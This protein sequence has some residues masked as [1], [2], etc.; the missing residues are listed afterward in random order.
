M[1]L[2]VENEAGNLQSVHGVRSFLAKQLQIEPEIWHAVGNDQWQLV[3]DPIVRKTLACTGEPTLKCLNEFNYQYTLPLGQHAG[4][5]L[6]ANG[7]IN[8]EDPELWL[9]LANA[10]CNELKLRSDNQL[11]KLENEQF[12]RQAI[13]SYEELNFLKSATHEMGNA[14]LTAGVPPF[15]ETILNSLRNSIN[16]QTIG[17]IVNQKHELISSMGISGAI[18]AC[19][20]RSVWPD[21]DRIVDKFSDSVSN[22]PFIKNHCECD[23]ECDE[24]DFLNNF[25]ITSLLHEEVVIGWLVAVNRNGLE[26]GPSQLGSSV[27]ASEREFGTIEATILEA[28]ST[29]IKTHITNVNSVREQEN[30]LTSTVKSLVSALDAKDPYTCG[31]GERVALFAQLIATRMELDENQ[32]EQI[33]LTGLLHDI[34]KIGVSEQTL[35]HP[36][37]LSPQQFDVIKMHP[38]SG[39]AI[40]QGI[41]Q[42]EYVLPGVLFHHERIDGAGYPDN[43]VADAIP[44]EARILA[45]ADAYDAMTSNRPYRNGMA[46]ERAA[47]I[48][49]EGCGTQWDE[50]IVSIFLHDEVEIE[51]IRNRAPGI[52]TLKRKRGS[53]ACED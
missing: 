2:S 28:A 14:D 6:V 4:K 30:L 15:I 52:K 11:L 35:N 47:K 13:D 27:F 9:R 41:K 24:F 20:D 43:L 46:H 37:T 18:V 19:L 12:A 5:Q 33:Y 22:K 21:V 51:K 16:A 49:R 1:H 39:W 44:L 48:L 40:L 32:I 38:H 31:H 23:E 42:L 36:G 10:V 34:G 50:Q 3:N 26:F 7:Q 45:V 25:I 17:L 8:T 53:I 29:I